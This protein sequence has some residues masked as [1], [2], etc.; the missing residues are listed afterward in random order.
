MSQAYTKGKIGIGISTRDRY[1]VFRDS[2]TKWTEHTPDNIKLVIIDDAS[3][4]A[5][6]E[7]SFRFSRNVGIARS[8]NKALELLDD[9]EHIFL[10]DDDVYPKRGD[11]WKPYIEAGVD[12]LCFTFPSVANGGMTSKI[13]AET[14]ST[15]VWS[16]PRG[17]FMY[18]H[19]RVLDTVGGLNTR[20]DKW[21][22]EHKDWS[23]R[24]HNA[25]L[26]DHPYMDVKDSSK[27]L[28]SM[29]QTGQVATTTPKRQQKLYLAR[30][31]EEYKKSLTSKEYMEYKDD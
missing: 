3:A 29:D 14:D 13:L 9:C 18:I 16:H 11:W 27:Y 1:R 19:H 7:A 24:I 4:I 2:L 28:Y 22:Y 30:G 12:H 26:T 6:K 21:G 15:V 5:V 10:A 23:N 20:Y 31:A 8:K 25:G 17:C